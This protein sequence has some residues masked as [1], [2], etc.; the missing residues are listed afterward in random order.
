M[1]VPETVMA[2]FNIRDRFV[3]RFSQGM[4]N[5]EREEQPWFIIK[6]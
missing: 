5:I 3:R 4:S 6:K 1:Y 2:E